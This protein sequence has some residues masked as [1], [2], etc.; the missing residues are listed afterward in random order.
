MSLRVCVCVRI[1]AI[2]QAQRAVE[3]LR[4]HRTQTVMTAKWLQYQETLTG[5]HIRTVR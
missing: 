3:E 4:T 5:Q 2:Q 1:Q